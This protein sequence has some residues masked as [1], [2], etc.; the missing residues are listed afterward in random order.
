VNRNGEL[1]YAIQCEGARI[2][3]AAQQRDSGRVFAAGVRALAMKLQ[4]SRMAV[5]DALEGESCE[6]IE[7]C[8]SKERATRCA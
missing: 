3:P 1:F 5:L 7:T 8:L 6:E 2:I 4:V